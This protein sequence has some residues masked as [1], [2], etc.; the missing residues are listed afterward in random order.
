MS[1]YLALTGDVVFN[2]VTQP[3]NYKGDEKYSLTVA[4]DKEGAKV[5]EKAGLKL[6]E[7]KG[8]KQITAKRKVD[9]GAPKV[10]NVDK[11]EVDI[12]QLSLFGDSVTMLVK[13]GKAP[14]DAY[15]YLERIRIESK[16]EGASDYDPSEF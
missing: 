3:D 15:T 7:Y 11:E 12:N 16:A 2:H 1:D 5:A 14:Y 13:Q 4:L 9:F 10:Y 8:V 6:S